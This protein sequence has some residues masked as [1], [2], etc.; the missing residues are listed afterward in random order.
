MTYADYRKEIVA[1]DK[2]VP[3]GLQVMIEG[4]SEP[5][6]VRDRGK[7]V[8]GNHLDVLMESHRAARKWGV[9]YKD[10]WVWQQVE[11]ETRENV[12]IPETAGN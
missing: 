2:V 11:M 6:T 12:L 8:K 3:F 1:A 4:F 5:H 10:V 9:Q 7:K